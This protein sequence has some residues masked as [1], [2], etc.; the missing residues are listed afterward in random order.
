MQKQRSYT[1]SA[2]KLALIGSAVMLF[3]FLMGAVCNAQLLSGVVTRDNAPVPNARIIV[4][5]PVPFE[6]VVAATR[7]DS[8]GNYSISLPST[9][10]F[11][12]T[13]NALNAVPQTD[14]EV[15]LD[16]SNPDVT[17]NIE[18]LFGVTPLLDDFS[19]TSLDMISKWEYFNAY[20]YPGQVLGPDTIAE[21][22]PEKWLKLHSASVRGG[23]K[24]KASFPTVCAIECTF[25]RQYI[26]TNNVYQGLSFIGT[27]AEDLSQFLAA[28]DCMP[29]SPLAPRIFGTFGSGPTS[30]SFF[31]NKDNGATYSY[32]VKLAILRTGDYYD[33]YVNGEW[34]TEKNYTAIPGNAHVYLYATTSSTATLYKTISH[35]DD[36][37]AGVPER[38][39]SAVETLADARSAGDNQPVSVANEVVTASFSDAFWIESTDRSAG[40]K[41]VSNEK[42]EIG[43][44]VSVYGKKVMINN[45]AV[46]QADGLMI[47]GDA[48]LPAPV[49]ITGKIANELNKEGATA[50]GL[51]VK[52]A[53]K[54]TDITTDGD[55]LTG[56]YLDDGSG[57]G[58]NG[59]PKG[60]YVIVDAE[61]RY[62]SNMAQ[63]DQ[64]IIAEGPLTVACP[65]E[66]NI[67]PAV[68][69]ARMEEPDTFTA[70]NDFCW[71][72]GQLDEKITKYTT[73]NGKTGGYLVDFDDEGKILP[74]KVTMTN[75]GVYN[76][77]AGNGAEPPSSTDAY[78]VFGNKVSL[79]G[80]V[81]TNASGWW[82]ELTFSG[83][84]PDCQYEFA[85]T[86]TRSSSSTLLTTYTI[87]DAEA[88]T[89][90]SSLGTTISPTG[91]STT[92]NTANNDV[93]GYIARWTDI[94]PAADGTFR[95][96]AVSGNGKSS[97][98]PFGA[99]ML[100]KKPS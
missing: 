29:G 91:E 88:F 7:T 95:I 56:Y 35:F 3:V 10:T 32:P 27:G 89:N 87:L 54:V 42:P 49:G 83:L 4:T 58:G 23:I 28:E 47:G 17:K 97:G 82:V 15:E 85:C 38:D 50:Q 46:I 48:T 2:S 19:D 80:G 25:P 40:I 37:R 86:A 51:Y 9:G 34:I 69:L 67:V 13:V 74:V 53:G 41:V 71:I 59:T 65:D 45:E 94:K 73:L 21:I 44:K 36:V 100:K 43:K 81:Y 68:R 66:V 11:K 60:V 20:P 8:T 93:N 22:T 75:S 92:I 14:I 78:S 30:T 98:Y 99:F 70:Y 31:W 84:K 12:L 62:Q 63:I 26:S 18:L 1:G 24:S 33:L 39:S 64:F 16:Y 5:G 76:I 72:S 79:T 90:T 77:I 6:S 96:R 57:I 52:I 55:Y 61:W